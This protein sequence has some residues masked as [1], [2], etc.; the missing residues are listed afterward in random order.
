MT[1][2]PSF[3]VGKGMLQDGIAGARD[4]D[5]I[6]T[7]GAERAHGRG[8]SAAIGRDR[9]KP[10]VAWLLQFGDDVV[11]RQKRRRVGLF[12]QDLEDP[13]RPA[14]GLSAGGDQMSEWF[15]PFFGFG[16]VGD[17][18]VHGASLLL[19]WMVEMSVCAVA[20]PHRRPI[21]QRSPSAAGRSRRFSTLSQNPTA[22][23]KVVR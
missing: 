2:L 11:K 10:F 6:D 22:S 4:V 7:D 21:C 17:S 1:S 23:D 14:G 18:F 12:L 5:D 8:E 16:G 3:F 20:G 15:L 13:H 19:R 9:R